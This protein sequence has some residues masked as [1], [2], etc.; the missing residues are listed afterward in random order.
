[1]EVSLRH[2]ASFVGAGNPSNEADIHM[3]AARCFR[4]YAV[5]RKKNYLF[6]LEKLAEIGTKVC[7]PISN[8]SGKVSN[9]FSH[10]LAVASRSSLAPSAISLR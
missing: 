4:G 2:A 10:S 8:H 7:N 3:D 1:M 5:S 6:Y 9:R